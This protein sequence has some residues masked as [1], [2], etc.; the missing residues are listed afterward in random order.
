VCASLCCMQAKDAL[1]GIID[2]M[3]D[4]DMP[5][6]IDPA[7]L[8]FPYKVDQETGRCEKLS[9][10]NTFCTVYLDRPIL[11]NLD[12]ATKAMGFPM[13]LFWPSNAEACNHYLTE[14]G[15][16]KDQQIDLDRLRMDLLQQSVERGKRPPLAEPQEPQAS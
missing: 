6:N 14:A 4:P 8:H 1:K 11:C 3:T 16:P 2:L 15:I 13:E 9:A 5:M 10:D 7:I 12:K